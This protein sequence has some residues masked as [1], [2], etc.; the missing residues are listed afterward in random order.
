MEKTDIQ[1]GMNHPK[2]SVLMAVYAK[3]NLTGSA[4]RSI[5]C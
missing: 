2:Y 5:P 4:L 3:D 1:K